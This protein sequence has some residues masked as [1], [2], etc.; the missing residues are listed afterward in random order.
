[1]TEDATYNAFLGQHYLADRI[2]EFGG[3]YPLALAAYNAGPHR[4]R[5]WLR[6][7]GDPRRPGVEIIDWVE[8]IPFNETRNYVQRVLEAT[9]V[10]RLLLEPDADPLPI[11]P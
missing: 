7:F 9:A 8:S 1:M 10:Y 2:D 3:S 11:R 6:Q 5:T 4:V